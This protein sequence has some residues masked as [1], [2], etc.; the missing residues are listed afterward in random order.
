MQL[1]Y[2]NVARE[3]MEDKYNIERRIYGAGAKTAIKPMT[4]KQQ[5]ETLIKKYSLP[6]GMITEE[7]TLDDVK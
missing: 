1:D 4:E 7:S 3:P 6:E 2:G 5:I